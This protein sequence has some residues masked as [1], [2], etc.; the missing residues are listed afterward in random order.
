MFGLCFGFPSG[1]ALVLG[2]APLPPTLGPISWT[3]LVQTDRHMYYGL[4]LLGIDVSDALVPPP[5]AA[6]GGDGGGAPSGAQ[7]TAQSAASYT[8]LPGLDPLA[9]KWG[10]GTVLDSGSNMNYLP[11]PV[12]KLLVAHLNATLRARGK[13]LW[14][15]R[16]VRFG[17]ARLLLCSANRVGA[18][19]LTA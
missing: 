7:P 9:F 17:S 11:A 6:G 19:G 12:F 3:P 2:D 8:Q 15:V 5:G 4:N 18:E 13:E 1:G 10:Y 16:R 14:K